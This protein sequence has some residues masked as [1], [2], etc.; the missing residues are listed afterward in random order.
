MVLACLK[1]RLKDPKIMFED[2]SVDDFQGQELQLI[3][4]TSKDFTRN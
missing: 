4:V 1:S 2:Q 3:L